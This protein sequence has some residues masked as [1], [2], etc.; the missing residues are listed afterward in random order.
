MAN[1]GSKYPKFKNEK[2]YG[3]DISEFG[4]NYFR[5]LG[6]VYFDWMTL[7]Y[8]SYPEQETFFRKDGFFTLLAGN[9]SLQTQIESGMTAEELSVTWQSDVIEFKLIRKKYLLYE[10]FE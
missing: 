2:C 10:D 8:Q 6:V 5:T 4:A 1:V 3:L 9:K 7:F